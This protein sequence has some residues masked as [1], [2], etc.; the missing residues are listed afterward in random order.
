MGKKKKNQLAWEPERKTTVGRKKLSILMPLMAFFSF[1]F[2]HGAGVFI[3]H[4]ALKIF[5]PDL[6]STAMGITVF[7]HLCPSKDAKLL[8]ISCVAGG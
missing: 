5:L 1:C 2:D 7:C 8:D 4:G 3:L 6:L